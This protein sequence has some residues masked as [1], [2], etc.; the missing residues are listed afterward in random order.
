MYTVKTHARR[1]NSKL[2]VQRR[3]HAVAK[4]KNEG[5]LN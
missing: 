2:G 4:A 3:T 5:W 1:I